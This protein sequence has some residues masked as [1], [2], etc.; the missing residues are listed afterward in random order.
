MITFTVTAKL[1]C[2]FAFAYSDCWFCDAA[3]QINVISVGSGQKSVDLISKHDHK[4]VYKL[5]TTLP[6]IV[7]TLSLHIVRFKVKSI[8][9]QIIF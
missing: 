2:V 7:F 5:L 1:I 9:N 8:V 3:A 6:M 4:S